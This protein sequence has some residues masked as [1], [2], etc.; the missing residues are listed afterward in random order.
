M[1]S[2]SGY[3]MLYNNYHYHSDMKATITDA[4]SNPNVVGGI[5]Q[6]SSSVSSVPSTTYPTTTSE[7]HGTIR[8]HNSHGDGPRGDNRKVTDMDLDMAI[9]KGM[10]NQESEIADSSDGQIGHGRQHI[11]TI[12]GGC[13][14]MWKVEIGE[15]GV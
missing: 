15:G 8:H 13:I 9:I 3:V 2:Y 6:S 1:V 11:Q 4:P 10:S 7:R 5:F 12:L 14:R